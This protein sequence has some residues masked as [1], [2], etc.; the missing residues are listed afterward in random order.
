MSPPVYV[1]VNGKLYS[2]KRGWVTIVQINESNTTV[3][4]E[5][6]DQVAIE[7]ITPELYRPPVKAVKAKTAKEW[8]LRRLPRDIRERAERN[9]E[10]VG[11]D[12]TRLYDNPWDA[13][14]DI[15]INSTPEGSK[16]WLE[17]LRCLKLGTLS[18]AFPTPPPKAESERYR[19][20]E[21][22]K[23]AVE[24]LLELERKSNECGDKD[25]SRF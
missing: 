19:I 6:G 4:V 2:S 25:D 5:G 17:V 13:L 9:F 15:P 24:Q 3:W 21:Q 22:L 1:E 23:E 12:E 8:F 14:N 11:L 16:F 20:L 7:F 18:R 10:R